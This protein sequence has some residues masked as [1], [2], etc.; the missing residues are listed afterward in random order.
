MLPAPGSDSHIRKTGESSDATRFHILP[1]TGVLLEQ[2]PESASR[3]T[4]G[5]RPA[6]ILFT[7]GRRKK[8]VRTSSARSPDLLKKAR[9]EWGLQK[10]QML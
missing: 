8:V 1:V 7:S 6:R 2:H 9:D 10:S 5:V 4:E 3:G